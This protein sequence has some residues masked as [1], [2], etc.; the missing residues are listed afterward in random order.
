V[1]S[2]F[3]THKVAAADRALKHSVERINGCI[4]FRAL[5]EPNL[6]KWLAKQP[7]Q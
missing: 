3:S 2:Y 5:Q 7:A 6:K 1:K 4:E